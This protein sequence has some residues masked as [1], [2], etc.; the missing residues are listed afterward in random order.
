M[1]TW[2]SFA[3]QGNGLRVQDAKGREVSKGR[4]REPVPSRTCPKLE[5]HALKRVRQVAHPVGGVLLFPV[6]ERLKRSDRSASCPAGVH[7]V[8][9]RHL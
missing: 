2:G 9:L 7:G 8:P 1:V 3:R 5:D 4:S 6:V